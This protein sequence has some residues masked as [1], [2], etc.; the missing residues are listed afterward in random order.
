[1]DKQKGIEILEKI[2]EKA[3]EHKYL[4]EGNPSLIQK[5]SSKDFLYRKENKLKILS[6][7][8]NYQKNIKF[9]TSYGG[10][11]SIVRNKH[12]LDKSK[13]FF[14]WFD[15]NLFGDIFDPENKENKIFHPSEDV[16]NFLEKIHKGEKK[17]EEGVCK[18]ILNIEKN[19]HE[20]IKRALEFSREDEKNSESIGIS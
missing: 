5:T 6:F 14:Y 3:K 10:Y 4:W 7:Q 16:Y 2:L 13:E 17:N 11:V 15:G 18:D 19:F 8:S 20:G 12:A 1:M 9:S